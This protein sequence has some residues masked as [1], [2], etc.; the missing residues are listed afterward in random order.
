MT[1]AGVCA[2]W[3]RS[4]ET[5]VPVG[6]VNFQSTVAVDDRE[7]LLTEVLD[8]VNERVSRAKRLRGGLFYLENFP[9]NATGK[10]LRRDLPARRE[11]LMAK[12]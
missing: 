3:D 8:Y 6:Y 11:M 4:L 2:A 5:E 1:E 7:R 12:L 9:R 10:L